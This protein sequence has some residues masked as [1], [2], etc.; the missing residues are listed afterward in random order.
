MTDIVN[1]QSNIVYSYPET[2]Y[3]FNC[4]NNLRLLRQKK[5][6]STI[7]FNLENKIDITILFDM[8]NFIKNEQK[9]NRFVRIPWE[10]FEIPQHIIDLIKKNNYNQKSLDFYPSRFIFGYKTLRELDPIILNKICKNFGFNLCE[11]FIILKKYI[12]NEISSFFPKNQFYSEEEEISSLKLFQEIMEPKK[13][14]KIY[15]KD[16]NDLIIFN[17]YFLTVFTDNYIL[18]IPNGKNI[19]NNYFL[20]TNGKMYIKTDKFELVEVYKKEFQNDNYI[21][22]TYGY[23]KNEN[24]SEIFNYSI[25]SDLN[26]K[27]FYEFNN[28]ETKFKM[29]LSGLSNYKKNIS[30]NKY[31]KADC[32]FVEYCDYNTNFRQIISQ[33]MIADNNDGSGLRYRGK[34]T[35]TSLNGENIKKTI[36][37]DDKIVF[38]KEGDETKTNLLVDKKKYMNR[39]E[40]IIGYKVAKSAQGELRIIKLGIT[41][42]AQIVRPIDE[43]YFINHNKERCNKAIVMDI[44]LPIKEE[45][46]SVVPTES[47]A[48]SYVYKSGKNDFNYKIGTEVIPDAFE[49]NEY[50]GC[51]QG[52]HYF[53]NR[54]DVFKA[55]ID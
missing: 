3:Q 39:T 36:T 54:L 30:I 43:E 49:P 26:I 18:L 41:P 7:N 4:A 14:L 31:I 52:I 51:A 47:V 10:K 48:Y 53:Q 50:I 12:I 11:E 1:F 13:L 21:Y 16:Y 19:K 55:Y 22:R 44:Q 32:E 28:K 9:L 8:I 35:G 23:I 25:D 29:K 15:S 34:Y 38:D 2:F 24:K 17:K 40:L 45:E 27:Q 5:W 33:C 42:D 37:F 6:K 20:L 46:I